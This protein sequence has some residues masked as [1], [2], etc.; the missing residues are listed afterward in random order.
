MAGNDEK[1][2]FLRIDEQISIDYRIITLGDKPHEN[3]RFSGLA[4]MD[5][6]SEGGILFEYHDSIPVGSLM[7]LAFNMGKP[8]PLFMKGRVKHVKQLGVNRFAIGIQF[9]ANVKEDKKALMDYIEEK[10][11]KRKEKKIT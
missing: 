1:R 11:K 3:L 5:N 2:Q 10:S 9:L 7:E 6:I 8:S 4:D